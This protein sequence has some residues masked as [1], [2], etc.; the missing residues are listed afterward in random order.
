MWEKIVLNLLSNAFKFT[1]E[2]EIAVELRTSADQR[3]AELTIRDTGVGVPASELPRLFE[4]FHRIEGQ[5]SRSFEGSG[6]GLALVQELV[7]LHG[8]TIR[9]ESELGK[10]T[11]F[12]IS[13]PFGAG[14]L[15]ADQLG[16]QR[17][18]VSTSLRAEA[19]VEEALRWLPEAASGAP[20]D[21]TDDAPEWLA[22]GRADGARILVA[23][24]NADMRNYVRRLLGS[25]WSV[26]TVAD[27]HDALAAMRAKK[28]D[29][30]LTDVMMPRLDGFGLAARSSQ[31]SRLAGSSGD[32]AVRTRRRRR[33]G[34]RL[35]CRS[36]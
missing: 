1:F 36:G 33:A 9:A 31:R 12:T 35:G 20:D 30:L 21:R 23:D 34:G 18:R 16:K 6:I 13:I 10:G 26:E 3:C 14:H 17:S 22:Q 29:L 32:H 8:G 2:G 4:R 5:R 25:R 24:D 19:F 11:A 15:A 27:G 28:P 7:K